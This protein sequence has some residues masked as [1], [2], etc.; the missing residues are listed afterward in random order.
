[1][2]KDGKK[3]DESGRDVIIRVYS[4]DSPMADPMEEPDDWRQHRSRQPTVMLLYRSECGPPNATHHREDYGDIS[5]RAKASK[6]VLWMVANAADDGS[7]ITCIASNPLIP[8]HGEWHKHAH[9][10]HF[11]MGLFLSLQ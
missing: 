4:V 3:I 10:Q 7:E 1:M 11:L 2:L 8:S 9:F 5:S 6:S